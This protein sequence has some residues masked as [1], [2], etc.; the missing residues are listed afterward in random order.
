MTLD[1]HSRRFS[2]SADILFGDYLAG[3]SSH[4]YDEV[5]YNPPTAGI[6]HTQ[7]LNVENF[8]DTKYQR[9]GSQY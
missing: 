9:I 5:V 6:Y 7:I 3:R 8:A 4:A 2:T 1:Y